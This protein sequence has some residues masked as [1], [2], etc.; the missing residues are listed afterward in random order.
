M[1]EVVL[2]VS[3]TGPSGRHFVDRPERVVVTEA[4]GRYL[5]RVGTLLDQL[6]QATVDLQRLETSRVLTV[7]AMP[8]MVSRWLIP[9]LGRLTERHPELDVRIVAKVPR[10]DFAR[11]EVDVAIRTGPGSYSRLCSTWSWP[12]RS[13][14]TATGCAATC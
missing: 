13:L 10:T 14:P 5:A 8:S 9:R 3:G 6:D 7:S 11:E 1:E 2:Q 4:G 12:K